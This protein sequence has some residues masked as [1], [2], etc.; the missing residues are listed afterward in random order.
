MIV[1]TRYYKT[2]A[3]NMFLTIITVSF[4]PVFFVS[5]TIFYQFNLSHRDKTISHIVEIMQKH[6]LHIDSFLQQK[7]ADILFLSKSAGI[8]NLL[9][10]PF[11]RQE[12]VLLQKI[13]GP[14]FVDIGLINSDGV[15]VTYAGPYALEKASYEHTEWFVHALEQP[16]LISDVFLGLRGMPHFIVAIRETVQS[17]PWILRAT[18]DFMEFSN[19][20]TQIRVGTTGFAYIVNREGK[21]QT[22]PIFDVPESVEAILEEFRQPPARETDV[23]IL[24]RAAPNGKEVLYAGIWMKNN[25]WLLIYQQNKSDA[26][27]ELYRVQWISIGIFILGGMA[28]ISMAWLISRKM[29]DR[30]AIADREKEAMNQQVIET[31]KLASIGELAA[32]IAHEINNPV[33][34]M[35]EEAGWIQD[36]LEEEDV[37]NSPNFDEIQQAVEQIRAQGTRC[38]EITHKLLSFARKTDSR[39]QSIQLNQLITDIISLYEQRI[40]YGNI[41]VITAFD[42]A[43]PMIEGS[44][45]ELQQVLMNLLNNALDAM[46]KVKGGELTISTRTEA[47][48]VV[49]DIRDNGMG[50][51]EANLNRIFD[52]FF[53]TKPVGKG[54]GLGLSI[55]YGILQKMGGD[56]LVSSKLNE[57][58]TFSLIFPKS[59]EDAPTA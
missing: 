34:I 41:K 14:V 29:V 12:L 32:G 58:T 15:Q 5:A 26:F 50:I 23:R 52:P 3:R 33:A 31:G 24:E 13:Y 7:L 30:I 22:K 54:T 27:S 38:K 9:S 43:L 18:I 17:K 21:F 6:K 47:D 37:R 44:V 46:E 8:T 19:M 42:P 53:T 2:L 49:V 11:L 45:S 51:P 59:R 10:E 56:I 40:R 39:L 20:V 48:K 57:G 35:V 28:I 55:C 25:D 36:L 16:F 1:N 4:V